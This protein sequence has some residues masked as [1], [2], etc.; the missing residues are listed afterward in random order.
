MNKYRAKSGKIRQIDKR[1]A[2]RREA[3]ARFDGG[4]SA[5]CQKYAEYLQWF[6]LASRGLVSIR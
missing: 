3:F 6:R 2:R 4:Y 5:Y 1:T